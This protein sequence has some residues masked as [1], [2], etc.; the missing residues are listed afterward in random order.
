MKRSLRCS[1]ET[2]GETPQ[3]TEA[4]SQNYGRVRSRDMVWL[5]RSVLAIRWHQTESPATKDWSDLL[6]QQP[7]IHRLLELVRKPVAVAFIWIGSRDFPCRGGPG[8]LAFQTHYPLLNRPP[9]CS[10]VVRP[11]RDHR[12]CWV[13]VV[14]DYGYSHRP[15]PRK[16]NHAHVR[17]TRRPFQATARVGLPSQ[18]G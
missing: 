6:N 11:T 13:A 1:T 14:L 2:N 3:S 18:A 16:T 5:H 10:G 4:T 17:S 7:R 9:R 12:H 8:P 15:S